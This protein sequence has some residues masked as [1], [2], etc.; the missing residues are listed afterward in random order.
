MRTYI[1]TY[2]LALL[3]VT[4]LTP[5]V[6]DW[7]R[8]RNLMDKPSARKIHKTPIARVGGIAIFCGAVLAI[9]PV[10]L[11]DN[12][13]GEVFRERVLQIVALLIACTVMFLVGLYDDL[14]KAH[15]HTK[16]G[17]QVFA[18]LVVCAAGIHVESIHI[19]EMGSLHLGWFGY[20]I[21]FVWIIGI[22]NAVN[23]ID[24]LDGL[25]AGIVAIASGFMA[26]MAILQGTVVLAVIM[27]AL[28]GSLTGFLFFN[29]HPA[30]IFMG[31]CGS[32]FLGFTIATATIMTASKAEA[33]VGIGL[34]ILVLGIP[35]FDTLLSILRR[36]INRRG[37][38][39]P[40]RGH[41]HHRLIDMGLK[42]HHVAVIAYA[43]T[44][45][46]SGFGLFMLLTRSTMSI[47]MLVA[48]IA[49]ILLIFRMAG[50][51]ELHRSIE[52]I[53]KRR[54]LHNEQRKDRKKFEEAQLQL[55]NAKT[56]DQWWDCLCKAA[57]ALEF[58]RLCLELNN[59]GFSEKILAWS[60]DASEMTEDAD[61]ILEELL[62]VKI[63]LKR[64]N[65]G[66]RGCIEIQV[67]PN[68]SLEC[69][70]RRIALFT[71]LTDEYSIDGAANSQ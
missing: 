35:I 52:G 33:L 63:P 66:Q 12:H 21:T 29:F 59:D 47:T 30:K 28:F 65:N 68:G 2:C 13:V 57:Q 6:I 40:D 16:L 64:N 38:M 53:S 46:I 18:A 58:N 67:L 17:A 31:D 56:F 15:V 7:A 61:Q 44:A 32:L 42:Q 20:V 51:V 4:I 45:S 27:V 62:Q 37:I 55:Q 26:L 39:S 49:L 60:A 22:T 23:L 24:G 11:I 5:I 71:R 69:A 1:F 10:I 14:K 48:C 54:A 25:A 43:M 19:R 36:F 3:L 8:K 9:I 70:G 34:P 50:S 41:F